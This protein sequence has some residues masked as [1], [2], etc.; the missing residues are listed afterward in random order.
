MRKLL[1]AVIAVVTALA[2]AGIAIAENVYDLPKS[3]TFKKG[4]GS[5]SNP[6]PK[7]VSFDYTV[8]DSAGP[9]GAPVK[10]YKIQFQGLT[11]KYQNKF[12]QCSFG[13]TDDN[14]PL[15]TVM[16]K[17]GKAKVGGGRIESLV[18]FDG[19]CPGPNDVDLLR[20]P[21]AH[22]FQH[23][24]RPV[25]PARRRAAGTQRARTGPSV[26]R[27]G[28]ARGDQRYG[29]SRVKINGIKSSSLEFDVPE[30][31]RHNNGL[32][33]TV[34][35]TASKIDRKVKKVKINGKTR[36]V[37]VYS[38]IGCAKN[39][40]RI[41]RVTFVDE[42][43]QVDQ[44]ERHRP[45]LDGS[46]GSVSSAGRLRAPRCRSRTRWPAAGEERPRSR[47]PRR[48]GPRGPRRRP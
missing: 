45:L 19:S 15:A 20:Q 35:R 22:A 43:E 33:I 14:A 29:T 3:S 42:T 41:V 31:L 37:G 11:T 9:R 39:G 6:V 28:N 12:P 26:A 4:K 32:T 23:P 44:G 38:A 40:K 13:D 46:A 21:A 24:G 8:K 30:E 5:P 7:G 25:D 2:V 36:K 1:I 48:R 34:A 27:A 10:T 47:R 18:A 17:C 16:A